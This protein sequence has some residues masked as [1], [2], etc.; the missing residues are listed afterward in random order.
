LSPRGV[1]HAGD[2]IDTGDQAN[3]KAQRTEW[4]A[5]VGAFGL[6]GNDGKLRFPI[7][8]VHG[9]HDAPRGDGLAVQ[10]IIARNKTRPGVT[11]TSPN[12]LHYSWDWDDI[13]FVCLGI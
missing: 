3:A 12:G 9:N 11:N 13:H 8:E 7:Y 4:S 2:C 10:Q 1:I 5:Y 6:T